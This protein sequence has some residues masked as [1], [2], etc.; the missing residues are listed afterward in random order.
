VI[1]ENQR[2]KGLAGSNPAV[3]VI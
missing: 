1:L 2:P 3:G